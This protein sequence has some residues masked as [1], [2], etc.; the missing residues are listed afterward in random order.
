MH[1]S[2]T[3]ALLSSASFGEQKPFLGEFT[4]RHPENRNAELLWH[5]GPFPLSVKD[6]ECKAE[7]VNQRE[8]FKVKKGEFSVARIDQ[9][10]EG[11]YTKEL[12]EFCKYFRYLKMVES[13]KTI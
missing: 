4:A 8:W 9:E 7:L 10:I 5:C 1:C 2:M 12:K 3:M 13:I 6:L 11:D